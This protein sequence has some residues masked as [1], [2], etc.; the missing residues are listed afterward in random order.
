MNDRFEEKLRGQ[1]F[2]QVPASWRREILSGTGVSPVSAE[3]LVTRTGGTPV[4]LSW[5][6]DWLWPSP[7]A[8]GAVAAA[9]A[10]IV[11]LQLASAQP[12]SNGNGGHLSGE[13]FQQRQILMTQILEARS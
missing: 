3:V 2:R 6:R 5:W 10:L 8:W 4:P 7:V 1:T 11:L 12:H 13:A 9:G